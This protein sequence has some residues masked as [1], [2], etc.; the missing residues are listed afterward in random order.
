MNSSDSSN[1]VN[2]GFFLF[3]FFI[4][5][6]ISFLLSLLLSKKYLA[7]KYFEIYRIFESVISFFKSMRDLF[8]NRPLIS[9]SSRDN[10]IILYL[11]S[12]GYD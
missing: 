3:F 5:I 11:L 1:G 4:L 10:L 6:E 8:L 12:D 2:L 7:S 9:I